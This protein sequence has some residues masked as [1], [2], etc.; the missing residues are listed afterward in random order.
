MTAWIALVGAIIGSFSAI[1]GVNAMS[2]ATDL[3]AASINAPSHRI[4]SATSLYLVAQIASAPT[5]LLWLKYG[6]PIKVSMIA[7]LFF[8]GASILC[9][10]ATNLDSFLLSRV[11]QGLS[12]GVLIA[13]PPIIIRCYFQECEHKKGLATYA[14]CGVMAP[15]TGPVLVG[16]LSGETIHYVFY[17]CAGLSL[18]AALL[19]RNNPKALILQPAQ[20]TSPG[21]LFAM[22]T[23]TIGLA[24]FVYTLES[25]ADL[26]WFESAYIRWGLIA[27][28][29]LI[30]LAIS[31]QLTN[32]NPLIPFR[33]AL[34]KDLTA[35]LITSF[36]MGIAI[37]GFM[38]LIPYYLIKA[39]ASS[40]KE[41]MY[42]VLYS[43]IPQAILLPIFIK[44]KDNLPSVYLIAVGGVCMTMGMYF[45]S[46][47]NVL[48]EGDQFALPQLLR[49]LGIPI[50]VLSLSLLL[51]QK[52][53]AN[54]IAG[55]VVL[56]GLC[57]SL[58]GALSIA[59][60]TAFVQTRQS[61]YIQGQLHNP[62]TDRINE[63]AW[64]Y[65]FSDMFSLL[66][67]FFAA[68]TCLLA[69]QAIMFFIRR[70]FPPIS[71]NT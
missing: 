56:Q 17:V 48:F 54:D 29:T 50:C 21:N 20:V 1:M 6:S 70:T 8:A 58:G 13:L 12:S 11:A 62:T 36:G 41:I 67:G 64:Q 25:G 10:T 19:M 27:S 55:A 7:S 5:A 31:H 68:M 33:I 4:S 24:G 34:N 59:V 57:R 38:Y 42:I 26:F 53:P 32:V 39:H 46:G 30:V 18:L 40:P 52:S 66:T 37:Y 3:L 28:L 45:L 49:A 60:M 44:V 2:S 63:I 61:A 65:A 15:I 9:A 14:F 51:I 23:F 35:I 16:G 69:F 22:A 71:L 43:A 47:V